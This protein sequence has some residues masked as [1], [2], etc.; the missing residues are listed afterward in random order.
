MNLRGELGLP[1]APP[2]ETRG[3]LVQ[4]TARCEVDF[5]PLDY[6]FE[7]GE[8]VEVIETDEATIT[9]LTR[10]VFKRLSVERSSNARCHRR[11]LSSPFKPSAAR[12]VSTREALPTF[13]RRGLL[14]K[15]ERQRPVRDS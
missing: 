11:A 3:F 14:R 4:N 1:K 6:R 13:S 7:A 2:P 5:R 12:P 15:A 10:T 9:D 8:V